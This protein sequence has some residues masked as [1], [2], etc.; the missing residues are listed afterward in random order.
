MSS[1]SVLCQSCHNDAL[2]K[3][4]TIIEVPD[5]HDNYM[6]GMSTP[7]YR[8]NTTGTYQTTVEGQFKRSWRH[9]TTCPEVMAIHKIIVTETS[10]R[11][12]QQY[13]CERRPVVFN[14]S[15]LLISFWG[16]QR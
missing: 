8:L 10:L 3:A 12:Y 16:S 7:L 14:L 1:T 6:S 11:Q 2:S 4:P 13:Q 9:K 5:D 15:N